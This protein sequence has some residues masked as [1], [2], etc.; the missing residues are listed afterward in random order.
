M[1][2]PPLQHGETRHCSGFEGQWNY[3]QCSGTRPL[4]TDPLQK[5]K[6]FDTTPK[7]TRR[8]MTHEE[9]QW[10]LTVAPSHRRLLYEV[11][12]CL[13]CGAMSCASLPRTIW[14]APQGGYYWRPGGRKTAS[15]SFCPY[16]GHCWSGCVTIRRQP[17]PSITWRTEGHSHSPS[18]PCRSYTSRV[19]LPPGWIKICRRQASPNT[20]RLG[21]STFTPSA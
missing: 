14:I 7:Q 10:L 15:N 12:C 17:W 21:S 9:I 2:L 3:P 8:A 4:G 1:T 6:Q 19:I 13:D 16:L 18:P 5:L 11:R 20:P